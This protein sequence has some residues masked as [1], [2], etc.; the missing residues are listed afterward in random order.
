MKAILIT[1]FG[2]LLFLMFTA[3]QLFVISPPP[4]YPG[5]VPGWP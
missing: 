5:T 2:G 3:L 4:H 1:I